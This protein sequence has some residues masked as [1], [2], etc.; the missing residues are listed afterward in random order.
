MIK[1]FTYGTLMFPEI[2]EVVA[3]KSFHYNDAELNGYIALSVK[4]QVFP[5]M[6]KSSQQTTSG[7]L[8]HDVN[9]EALQRIDAFESEM[10]NRLDIP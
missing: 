6:I 5:G 8:Y 7:V 4:D 10:Y 1:L 9:S 3:G 2:F